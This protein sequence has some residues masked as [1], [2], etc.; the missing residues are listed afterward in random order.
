MKHCLLLITY[1]LSRFSSSEGITY[2]RITS[3]TTAPSL[4]L[5]HIA[6]DI[7]HVQSQGYAYKLKDEYCTGS[8]I[9]RQVVITAAHCIRKKSRY[10]PLQSG[11]DVALLLL[12]KPIKVCEPNEQEHERIGIVKLP[13]GNT[14]YHWTDSD[15]KSAKCTMFGYGKHERHSKIDFRL[16]SMDVNLTTS[17]ALITNLTSIQKICSGDSG[18]PVICNR[19]ST[20]YLIGITTSV[21]SSRTSKIP[22]LCRLRTPDGE[23]AVVTA[24]KFYDVRKGVSQILRFLNVHGQIS[25]MLSDYW[26]C[27]KG[28]HRQ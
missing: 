6:Q 16:R 23:Y 3:R 7:R 24:A 22:Q 2:G 9:S 5:I 20:P 14:R 4:A 13:I 17:T 11:E 26:K 15:V 1:V 12:N 18:G 10:S 25:N 8:L 28:I 27:F 19:G 21:I